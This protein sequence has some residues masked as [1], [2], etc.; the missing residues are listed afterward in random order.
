M[1]YFFFIEGST[2]LSE[3]VSFCFFLCSKILEHYEPA[4]RQWYL[5]FRVNKTCRMRVHAHGTEHGV[6]PAGLGHN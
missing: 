4:D 2:V 5:S 6:D 1:V 3:R